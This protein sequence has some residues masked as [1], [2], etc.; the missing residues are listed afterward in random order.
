MNRRI[1]LASLLLSS[2]EESSLENRS[3]GVV[4]SHATYRQYYLCVRC[5]PR[6]L[7]Q[8]AGAPLVQDRAVGV[9]E[10]VDVTP[11][12]LPRGGGHVGG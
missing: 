1:Q 9:I 6:G 3:R 2:A 10:G 8:H 4:A 5:V 11:H 7:P 12:V